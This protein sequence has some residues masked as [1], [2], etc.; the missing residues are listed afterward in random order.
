MELVLKY[1]EGL[2]KFRLILYAIIL[3]IFFGCVD[4]LTG[5]EI[6]FSIFYLIPI[7]LVA[8]FVSRTA[9][10]LLSIISTIVWLTAELLYKVN[11]YWYTAIPLWNAFV[12][13]GIF[14]VV[15][16]LINSLK[17]LQ[18]QQTEYRER[19][20]V[21]EAVRKSEE[22][23]RSL[24][25][26]MSEGYYVIDRDGIFTYCSPNIYVKSGYTKDELIGNSSTRFVAKADRR[27]V[28]KI[29]V[30]AANQGCSD[31]TCEFRVRKKND[32]SF[33][34]EQ[35]T[36]I[37]RDVGG[38]V[39]EFRSIIR[40]ITQ[41]KRVE[42]QLCLLAHAVEST[43][44]MISI[45]DLD[46]RFIFVNKAFDE[47]YGYTKDEI[48][49]KNPS[50]LR[51][52]HLD[53]GLSEEIFLRTRSGGWNG[54]LI[55]VRKDGSE[56]PIMLSTSRIEDEDGNVL[57]LIGVA[58]DISEQKRAEEA[59][60][61]AEVRFEQLFT[62]ENEGSLENSSVPLLTK[63]T[64]DIRM[65]DLAMK[66]NDVTEKMRHQIRQTI[67]FSTLASHELRTPLMVIRHQLEGVLNIDSSFENLLTTLLSVYDE[68]LRLSR[69]IEQ[70]LTVGTLQSSTIKMQC[71]ELKLDEL[72]KKFYQEAL[73]LSRE[74]EV[75]IVLSHGPK[76]FMWGDEDHIRQMLFNLFDNALKHTPTGGHIRISYTIK[77]ET[78]ILQFSDTGT[79]IPSED[80]PRIFDPFFKSPSDAATR[81]GVG[82]GLTYVK[83]IV[84][85]HKGTI[86]VQS[87]VGKGTTFLIQF[88]AILPDTNVN[89]QFLSIQNN[90]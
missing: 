68:I 1:I 36:R 46:N 58:R 89:N 77:E 18:K 26:N 8:W 82:L 20:K 69:T 6:A 90:R 53:F 57:G 21:E 14:L 60:K 3:V 42:N 50:F 23:Y 59:L 54:E 61:R 79:G 75:S 87:E 84:H 86:K 81:P 34:V 9:G 73:L 74:K 12:R 63:N 28:I 10:V 39:V 70:F 55:N 4:Y 2:P 44:E 13:L 66:I 64:I 22:R 31:V 83:W 40:D 41:R 19:L 43:V 45:T 85:A 11:Y 29:Y 47:L 32:D 24:V 35:S 65:H 72:L 33:W 62:D 67:S 56:F 15:N 71:C 30:N 25:E 49:G 7:S 78:I 76:V 80:I 51:P 48:L 27:R 37:I 38:S 5:P 52:S 17:T 88:P 16:Q